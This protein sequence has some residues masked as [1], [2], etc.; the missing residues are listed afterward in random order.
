MAMVM[1]VA[2]DEVAMA[3]AARAMATV[4]M[5]AGDWWRWWRRGWWWWRQGWVRLVGNETGNGDGGKSDGDSSNM[6]R[7][8]NQP[9]WLDDERAAQWEGDETKRRRDDETTR[10]RED[11]TTRGWH[12]EMTRRRDDETTRR[13]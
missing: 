11:E 13:W 2:G 8:N 4:T 6:R 12:N 9:V 10:R 5:V 7:L 3:M 1:R